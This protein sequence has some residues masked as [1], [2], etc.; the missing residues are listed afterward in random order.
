MNRLSCAVVFVLVLSP[1]ISAQGPR[2]SPTNTGL[3][4]AAQLNK[5][6]DAKKLKI[7]DKV[8]A[9]VIQDVIVNGRIVIPRESKLVGRISAVEALSNSGESRVS[10]V[11][12]EGH[13][14]KDGNV[15]FQGVIEALGPPV[16]DPFLEAEMASASP[17][18]PASAGHPVPGP[19][20]Q[21]NTTT[22]PMQDRWGDSGAQ[23]LEQRQRALDDARRTGPHANA[24]SHAGALSVSSRGVFGLPGVFLSRGHGTSTIISVGK[25]VHLQSGSQM[26]VRLESLA[27]STEK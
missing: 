3:E 13:L 14:K 26:V 7:G 15:K 19:M 21:S 22:P 11:F 20:G 1:V 10:L 17:Y 27:R 25:N 4:V 12:D 6:L 9:Q 16:A 5:D 24:P 18:S 8:E 23:G 2:P